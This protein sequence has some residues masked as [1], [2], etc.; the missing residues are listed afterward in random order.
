MKYPR[1]IRYRPDEKDNI[2][3]A[4]SGVV[5]HKPTYGLV[6]YTGCMMIEM[7]LDHC[8][9][10]ANTVE[11]VSIPM[12]ID[13]AYIFTAIIREGA[14]LSASHPQSIRTR[15]HSSQPETPRDHV[16]PRRP[17]P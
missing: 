4:W 5:G 13:G 12:H 14:T 3:A 17:T 1:D 11:E 6:P 8:G 15:I 16:G 9:P 2:P 10:M 7:T